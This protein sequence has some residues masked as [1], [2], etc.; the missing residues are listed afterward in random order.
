ME[1]RLL[2]KEDAVLEGKTIFSQKEVEDFCAAFP[3]MPLQRK[4]DVLEKRLNNQLKMN[5]GSGSG[6]LTGSVRRAP[7]SVRITANPRER[8]IYGRII[9]SF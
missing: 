6:V 2:T 4:I 5:I 8:S 1:K 9:W 3:N 7:D